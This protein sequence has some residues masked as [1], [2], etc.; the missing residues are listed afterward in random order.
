[1]D[2]LSTVLAARGPAL[3]SVLFI[4]SAI[5]LASKVLGG[6]PVS[7]TPLV[8]ED[9]GGPNKRRTAYLERARELYKKG[10]ETFRGKPFRLTTLDGNI[11][12]PLLLL[13]PPP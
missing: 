4:L 8:G 12:P 1:M 5:F 9:L 11:N 10:Y 13:P 3:A 7:N 6:S 2:Q